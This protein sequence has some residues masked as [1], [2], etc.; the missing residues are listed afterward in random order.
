MGCVASSLTYLSVCREKEK[1]RRR[2]PAF[3]P[4]TPRPCMRSKR[5][6]YAMNRT[7]TSLGI[8][9]SSQLQWAQFFISFSSPA[10]T[11]A[12]GSRGDISDQSTHISS[13]FTALRA[14]KET[15]ECDESHVD[16]NILL[17]TGMMTAYALADRSMFLFLVLWHGLLL[18]AFRNEHNLYH[19]WIDC[20]TTWR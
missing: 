1:E 19:S 18:F 2:W 17:S 7:S 8:V 20:W 15:E 13:I 16:L 3:R 5:L 11:H 9:A 14:V 10:Y 6:R 12:S 4:P